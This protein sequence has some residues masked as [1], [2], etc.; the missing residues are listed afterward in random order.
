MRMLFAL[1]GL[2]LVFALGMFG[3]L[4]LFGTDSVVSTTEYVQIDGKKFGVLYPAKLSAKAPLVFYYPPTSRPTLIKFETPDE[5]K[6]GY[7]LRGENFL[8]TTLDSEGVV[9]VNSSSGTLKLCKTGWDHSLLESESKLA[10][11]LSG[12]YRDIEKY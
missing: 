7:A 3:Y 2:V 6:S 5:D 12:C 11:F 9:F 8:L 4:M 10:L 1:I